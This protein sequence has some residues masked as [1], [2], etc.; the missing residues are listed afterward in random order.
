MSIC[1]LLGVIRSVLD[2]FL[3]GCIIGNL[4]DA[5]RTSEGVDAPLGRDILEKIF[6][7]EIVSGPS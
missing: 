5:Y 4:I 7:G 2:S 3:R 6:A 1:Y